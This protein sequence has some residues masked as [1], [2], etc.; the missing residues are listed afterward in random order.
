METNSF[1]NFIDD[2]RTVEVVSTVQDDLLKDIDFRHY[3]YADW[4]Y[5]KIQEQIEEFQKNLSFDYDVCIQLASFGHSITMYVEEIGYQNPDIL[6]FWGTVNDNKAQLIQNA[7]Q[8]SFMLLAVPKKNP[9][10]KPHR[11]GFFI[12]DENDKKQ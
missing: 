9:D 10:E 12:Q 1:D 4:K 7:A 8:L 3:E 6:Y 2:P 11:I 5:E